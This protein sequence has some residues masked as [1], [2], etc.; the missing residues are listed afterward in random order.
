MTKD[1][2]PSPDPWRLKMTQNDLQWP[3]VTHNIQRRP[4]KARN[5]KKGQKWV[6]WSKWTKWHKWL[7][8]TNSRKSVRWSAVPVPC[9]SRLWLKLRGEQGSGPEGVDDLCF[10]TYGEFSPSPSPPP[11]YPPSNPSLEAQILASRLRRRDFPMCESIGHRPLW[12]RCPASPST[13]STIY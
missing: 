13:S 3:K 5:K 9:L 10:H 11:L 12:G 2:V 4:I 7:K 6:K 8:H 1:G